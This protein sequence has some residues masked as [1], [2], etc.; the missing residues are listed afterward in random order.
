MGQRAA[1]RKKKRRGS[2]A[3]KS[4]RWQNTWRYAAK[5]QRVDDAYLDRGIVVGIRVRDLVMRRG[6]RGRDKGEKERE[7]G[8]GFRARRS[9]KWAA[10]RG[11]RTVTERDGVTKGGTGALE[12]D[13]YPSF[14]GRGGVYTR[15]PWKRAGAFRQT[16]S[17]GPSTATILSPSHPTRVFLFLALFHPA[18]LP[19]CLPTPM[20]ASPR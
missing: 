7:R 2:G 14:R 20:A 19:A 16:P 5:S 15:C 17:G 4:T 10:G 1:R 12:W 3:L 9:R 11:E 6:G 18:Y 8:R 13:I